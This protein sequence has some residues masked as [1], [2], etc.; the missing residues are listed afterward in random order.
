MKRRSVKTVTLGGLSTVV[1]WLVASSALASS[2]AGMLSIDELTKYSDLVVHG[3]I[4]SIDSY[5]SNQHIFTEIEV[6][7]TE[8][9][10]GKTDENS[11]ILKLYGGTVNGIRTTVLGGPC[12]SMGEEVVLFL[13]SRDKETFDVLNLAEGKFSV[14]AG[15]QRV[16][17]DLS[18]ISYL[19]A[20]RPRIPETLDELK[21][22]IAA[23]Q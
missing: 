18:G 20:E 8:Q 7:V 13:K 15:T 16:V 23:A 19:S 17:R 10:K 2:S 1:S 9:L 21:A 6:M 14:Q 11:V 4:G 5:M 3:R 12:L 22:A